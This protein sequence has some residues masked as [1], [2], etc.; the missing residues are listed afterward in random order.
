MG[1]EKFEQLDVWQEA[2]ALVLEVYRGTSKMPSEE[3]FGLVSQMRRAA[4]S[5][6]ANIAEGFKRRG[7]ADRTHFYNIAQASLEELRYYFILCRDLGYKLEHAAIATQA[8]HV[9]RMLYD[10]VHAVEGRRQAA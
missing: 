10:L 2:H 1:I 5:V 7:Q 6:P 4:V 9:A 3:K 8:E